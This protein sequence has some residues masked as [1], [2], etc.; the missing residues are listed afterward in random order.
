MEACKQRKQNIPRLT[1]YQVKLRA[2]QESLS[3]DL[4]NIYPTVDCK[5]STPPCPIIL[6]TLS[7][8]SP[9]TDVDLKRKRGKNSGADV[10]AF[11]EFEYCEEWFVRSVFPTCAHEKTGRHSFCLFL[12]FVEK[13]LL[14]LLFTCI[15]LFNSLIFLSI[16]SSAVNSFYTLFSSSIFISSLYIAVGKRE[17]I[18]RPSKLTEVRLVAVWRG[19]ERGPYTMFRA[20]YDIEPRT[21]VG[22][23]SNC[24]GNN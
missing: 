5:C 2:T 7:T 12:F 21:P 24:R 20:I 8:W 23:P 19:C 17:V 6:S 9:K 14:K 16:A 3:F 15:S 13:D 10:Y 18:G 4:A 1:E 11:K 22:Q